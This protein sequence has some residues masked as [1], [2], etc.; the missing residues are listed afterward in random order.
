MNLNLASGD[1]ASVTGGRF[2]QASAPYA[3][4]GGGERNRASGTQSIVSGGANRAMF[5][6]PGNS[7]AG[8]GLFQ[9]N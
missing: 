8:G 7:W 5:A 6:A 4:V 9:P 1:G 3:S 2:N